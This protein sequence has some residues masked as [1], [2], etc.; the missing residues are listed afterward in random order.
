MSKV[1]FLGFL[2]SIFIVIS[3][4]QILSDKELITLAEA[5][6]KSYFPILKNEDFKIQLVQTG[7]NF[8]T[9]MIFV[10]EETIL[11]AQKSDGKVMVIK[12]LELQTEPALDLNVNSGHERGFTGLASIKSENQIFVFAYFTESVTDGDTYNPGTKFDGNENNG[13]KLV[14]Y[15][16]DGKSL[17]NPTLILHPILYSNTVHHGGVMTNV[18]EEL[19]LLV[20]NNN[21]KN[22]FLNNGSSEKFYD[23][24]VIFRINLDGEAISS[25]PFDDEKLSKYYSYGV[26][27][28]YGL[29]VDPITNQVWDTE[30]GNELFDEVNLIF[31]GFNSGWEK[32]MGPNGM[33][34]YS[35]E[36]S[37]LTSFEGSSYSDPEFSWEYTI[38]VTAMDFLKSQNYGIDYHNDLFIGDV[39]GTLYHFELNENRDGFVFS[40][41]ALSDL[42]SDAPVEA[43]SII[44]GE[45]LGIITDIKTGPDGYLYV[46]S[47]VQ[48]ETPSWPLWAGGVR[49]PDI[50]ER[51]SMLGVIFR[52]VPSSIFN[53][54][55]KIPSPR[56]Q[57]ENGFLPNSVTCNKGLELILKSKNN[58]PG[59]V[60]PTTAKKLIER[61]WTRV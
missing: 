4:F 45:N 52:I 59:C 50:E 46:T 60:K 42:V 15:E 10:D 25:N 27:N 40:D 8:P 47:M 19:F 22:N 12:N 21:N 53:Q 38:G 20:G 5:A 56:E 41:P 35:S 2:I 58:S 14:R 54:F 32:I 16:W 48:S 26:R 36:L 51:G 1:G 33:G 23:R 9:K 11:V 31:P 34:K 55:E 6:K 24:G 18:G 39:F 57:V 44:F 37:E 3:I 30:N 7:L 17:I 29:A 13:N 49:K 43:E 28:G 61:G